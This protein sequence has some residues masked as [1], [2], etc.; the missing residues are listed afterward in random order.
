M[1]TRAGIYIH[2]PFC[3]THCSYCD[4]AIWGYDSL[5]AERY[6]R[7]TVKEIESFKAGQDKVEIDSIYFGGGTPS[8]LTLA[9][10]EELLRA[11]HS[12][13][14]VVDNT[15]TTLEINPGT[16]SPENARALRQINVN[17]ASFGAQTF[18]DR[19][20][21][22]LGRTHT[23]D[24]ARRTF[25]DLRRAGFENISLDLIAGLP[26]QT[27]N[28]WSRNLDEAFRLCPDHLSFYLL[29]VHAGTPLERQINRGRLPSPDEDLAAQMYHLLIERAAGEGY[30][31]YEISNFC[32]PNRASRHNTKY[33]M[34]APVYGF[35]CAAHSF[36]GRFLR[37]SNERNAL[38][39]V[40]M[41]EAGRSPV[42]E[43]TE[44]DSNAAHAENIFL[45]LRLLERGVDLSAHKSRFGRDVRTEYADELARLSEA[46]LIR[47]D[48]E[49]MRL[50][51]AGALM[52]NEVFAVF[53]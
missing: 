35:G 26:A 46:G 44:L 1:T 28:E 29:E 22:R 21:R 13:F 24:D 43:T 10:I 18:D 50:T 12:R 33:W 17:R 6:V 2:I 5:L 39:Y 48:D 37:W 53:V 7:A 9:Q 40:E 20:L 49:R 41:I 31:H 30:A 42:V 51:S 45:N 27:L 19:H 47:F 14:R 25:A 4:F 34:L 32:L 52:S 11:V 3:L 8:L 23:A 38:K 15:E 36:D 16:L